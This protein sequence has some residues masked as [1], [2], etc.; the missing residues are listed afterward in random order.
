M[1]RIISFAI[2]FENR[3][4]IVYFNAVRKVELDN[5]LLKLWCMEKATITL[6][7]MITLKVYHSLPV[8][9]LDLTFR[10]FLMFEL[11]YLLPLIAFMLGWFLYFEIAA[12]IGSKIIKLT[13][14]GISFTSDAFFRSNLRFLLMFGLFSFDKLPLI[15][16]MLGCF[17][18]YFEIPAF[19]GSKRIKLKLFVF[20]F[21]KFY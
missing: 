3:L 18:L 1:N 4:D 17:F 5:E 2:F 9:F 19:I 10:V 16:L 15:T 13:L 8:A 21:R 11:Y 12:F 7:S 20:F 14:T 6:F